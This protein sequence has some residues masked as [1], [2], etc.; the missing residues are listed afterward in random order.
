MKV[1]DADESASSLVIVNFSY[2]LVKVNLTC[3]L[4]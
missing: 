1:N 2:Y 3:E 4:V